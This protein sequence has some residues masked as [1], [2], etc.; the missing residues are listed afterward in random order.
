MLASRERSVRFYC[1]SYGSSG[2]EF[3][4]FVNMAD[5]QSG[6]DCRN[7]LIGIEFQFVGDCPPHVQHQLPNEYHFFC[8]LFFCFLPHAWSKAEP[9]KPFLL[10]ITRR[11]RSNGISIIFSLPRTSTDPA[12]FKHPEDELWKQMI[13]LLFLIGRFGLLR[14]ICFIHRNRQRMSI[15]MVPRRKRDQ[16]IQVW[17]YC[18]SKFPADSDDL[19]RLASL[20]R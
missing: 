20:E 3:H 13:Q 4:R 2:Q 18:P 5:Q 11:G 8:P 15:A 17:N 1:C 16:L 9:Q 6:T 19:A 10:K 14:E 12:S 7:Q